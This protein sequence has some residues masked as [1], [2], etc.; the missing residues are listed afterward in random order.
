M[1][2]STDTPPINSPKPNETDVSDIGR[3]AFL[4]L[5]A[6]SSMIGAVAMLVFS[7]LFVFIE[8]FRPWA[9]IGGGIF[10]GVL[11]FVSSFALGI[12]DAIGERRKLARLAHR[13]KKLPEIPD[14]DFAA[15]FGALDADDVLAVRSRIAGFFSIPARRVHPDV[16]LTSDDGSTPFAFALPLY[17]VRGLAPEGSG[18]YEL[19]GYQLSDVKTVRDLVTE[20]CRLLAWRM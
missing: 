17:V 14:I 1:T 19:Q 4:P 2:N 3:I 10:G 16:S 5:L 18:A 15:R 11:A 9:W 6:I 12:R 8:T 7:V 13:F 20:I